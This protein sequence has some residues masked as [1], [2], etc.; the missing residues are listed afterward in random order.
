MTEALQGV[1]PSKKARKYPRSLA[2]LRA[3]VEREA[4][5]DSGEAAN[6]EDGMQ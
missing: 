2:A 1:S 5:I 6:G 3:Y 4:A